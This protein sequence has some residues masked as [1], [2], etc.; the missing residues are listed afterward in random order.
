M[1]VHVEF[2]QQ[3]LGAAQGSGGVH[4]VVR[5]RAAREQ[6]PLVAEGRCHRLI[7]DPAFHAPG[8]PLQGGLARHVRVEQH[9]ADE[10]QGQQVPQVARLDGGGQQRSQGTAAV[11]QARQRR[12]AQRPVI[13]LPAL[14]GIRAAA[15]G[16]PGLGIH[17]AAGQVEEMGAEPLPG[18]VRVEHR[19]A[20]LEPGGPG[21]EQRVRHGGLD[22]QPPVDLG[23]A[24]GITDQGPGIRVLQS[25]AG[26]QAGAHVR[27]DLR[28]GH[29]REQDQAFV[30]GR[31]RQ[32]I[33]DGEGGGA[34]DDGKALAIHLEFGDLPVP[35]LGLDRG[36]TERGLAL[37]RALLEVADLLAELC[38]CERHGAPGSSSAGCTCQATTTWSAPRSCTAS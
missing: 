9:F 16:E 15:P 32:A 24:V 10:A 19:R 25:S 28:L 18:G 31:C 29:R 37:F 38:G 11:A 30:V 34:P 35:L 7:A 23:D 8:A 14:G 3:R 2:C 1:G 6:C 12:G 27:A 26:L 4:A 13:G 21:G 5:Q 36:A 22:R 17:G 33:A 20:A